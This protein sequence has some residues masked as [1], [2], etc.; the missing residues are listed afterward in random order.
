MQGFEAERTVRNSEIGGHH[1]G[2]FEQIEIVEY[3]FGV[4]AE[5]FGDG[6]AFA[7]ELGGADKVLNNRHSMSCCGDVFGIE[8]VGINLE[9]D[10]IAFQCI[11]DEVATN[12][13]F[14]SPA[15]R[16]YGLYIRHKKR[17]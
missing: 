4:G 5:A 12:V 16:G 15:F 7:S 17:C 2:D 3:L 6:L 13:Y 11:Q 10:Y 9:T 8:I 14:F 1:S